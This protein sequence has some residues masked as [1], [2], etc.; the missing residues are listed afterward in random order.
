MT[1]STDSRFLLYSTLRSAFRPGLPGPLVI[2]DVTTDV[3]TTFALSQY[4]DEI[5]TDASSGP[6]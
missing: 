3:T 6:G 2:H 4:V 5:R 1:W